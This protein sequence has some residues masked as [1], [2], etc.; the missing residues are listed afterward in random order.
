[1]Y[2]DSHCH[3]E[4]EDFDDDRWN[5][6]EESLAEGL[7][8]M[9]TVGTEESYFGLVE[10]ITEKYPQIYGAI[11]IH[12]HNAAGFDGGAAKRLQDA[13]RGPKIVALGEIGLDFFKN[14][15]PGSV[16]IKAFEEQI[17]LASRMG[18]PVIVHSRS[19]PRETYDILLASKE[20]LGRGGVIHCFSYDLD[21]AKK[22]LDLGFFIS[23][24]GTITYTKNIS[25]AEVA[26]YVPSDRILSET[27]APFLAPHPYR[28]KRNLP[29][30][31]KATVAKV[32]EI[33]D[34]EKE[35]LASQIRKNFVAL[36]L[37]G[38]EGAPQ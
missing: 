13:L 1:M 9:L 11:G 2:V 32:A 33:R 36:F 16:Q 10:K 26:R 31:V 15:S 37:E 23:I 35:I 22:F 27:D 29:F 14:R 18:L 24:P 30:Y 20:S 8:Y 19:A 34:V 17:Q 6:I 7:D 21:Y 12:P 25:L 3:L 4:I 38:R 28:G 5:I